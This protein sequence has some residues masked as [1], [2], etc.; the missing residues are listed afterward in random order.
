MQTLMPAEPQNG[1]SSLLSKK[2]LAPA[3]EL[4]GVV[5]ADNAFAGVAV[6]RFANAGK[7]KLLHIAEH[8]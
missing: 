5:L 7:E 8:E 1:L 2:A 3:F 6:I 4:I